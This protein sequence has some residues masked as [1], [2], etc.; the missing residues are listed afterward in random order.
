MTK[1]FLLKGEKSLKK[2]YLVDIL[3]TV[4]GKNY[5]E[6]DIKKN[7]FGKEYIEGGLEFSITHAAGY[8]VLA[9]SDSP[10]GIDAAEIKTVFKP[11]EIF[12]VQTSSAKEYASLYATAEAVIKYLA[13][14]RIV[15]LKD[16]NLASNVTIKGE[17]L[18]AN[19]F[20]FI[21]D[22]LVISVVTSDSKIEIEEA[23]T[24][25]EL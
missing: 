19:S 1:L 5:D 21:K 22:D 11:V 7:A 10:V 24:P 18:A 2:T 4:Y 6:S 14:E 8:I 15:D 12:G 16:V 17:L 13:N 25:D 20:T 23:E 9:V 3:N